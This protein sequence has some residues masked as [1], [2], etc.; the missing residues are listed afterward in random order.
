MLRE[1]LTPDLTAAGTLAQL[2]LPALFER[3]IRALVLDV[4]RTLLPRRQ[5]CLPAAAESWLREARQHVPIHLLSNNPSRR[6]IG[7]VARAV[8][9]P[10]TTAAGKPRRSALRRVLVELDMPHDQVALVGDRVFTD[11]LAG[12]RLGMFT[13]LVKPIAVD[14]LPCRHDQLQEFER[15]LAHWLASTLA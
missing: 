8:D 11:V 4:D 7:T 5:A 10:F 6:R 12:N 14:G 13:V 3:G 9:L 2:A 1:L 15:R